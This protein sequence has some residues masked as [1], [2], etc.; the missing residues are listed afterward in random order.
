MHIP[1]HPAP[2]TA[3][4][5]FLICPWFAEKVE[6]IPTAVVRQKEIV[7]PWKPRKTISCMPVCER[8]QASVHAE[9]NK[10]P[11]TKEILRP[12]ISASE[13]ARRRVQP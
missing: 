8:P 11:A 12:M 13:L 1:L 10:H 6:I 9:Y 4:A 2:R 3:K 7:K 5:M